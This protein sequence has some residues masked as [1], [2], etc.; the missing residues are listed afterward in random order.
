M[1]Y[2]TSHNLTNVDGFAIIYILEMQIEQGHL[3]AVPALAGFI[4]V[5]IREV[6][7]VS[8]AD[9]VMKL[10]R[11]VER[12]KA[13]NAELMWMNTKLMDALAKCRDKEHARFMQLTELQDGIR[14]IMA[15]SKLVMPIKVQPRRGKTEAEMIDSA[16]MHSRV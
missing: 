8:H 7:N 4:L 12:L 11:E 13:S 16:V 10:C 9:E 5:W 14:N 2:K 6:N 15:A 3:P 1:L